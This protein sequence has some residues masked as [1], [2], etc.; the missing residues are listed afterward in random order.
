MR[1]VF[2]VLLTSSLT[3]CGGM[4]FKQE[5]ETLQQRK[6]AA[7]SEIQKQQQLQRVL[8]ANSHSKW[9]NSLTPQQHAQYLSAESNREASQL[10]QNS[11][12]LEGVGG[13]FRKLFEE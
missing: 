8:I 13:L 9:V 10:R 4:S 5:M 11:R 6:Q 1:T 12:I 2:I 3:G 7:I